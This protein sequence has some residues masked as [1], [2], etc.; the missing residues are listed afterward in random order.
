[1]NV[2]H[3]IVEATMPL[4]FFKKNLA[5]LDVEGVEIYTSQNGS[6]IQFSMVCW[7]ELK[8]AGLFDEATISQANESGSEVIEMHF[9]GVEGIETYQ[10]IAVS[11]QHLSRH[12]DLALSAAAQGVGKT[13]NMIMERDTGYFIKLYLDEDGEN[14]NHRPQLS[15]GAN[16]V[17]A[18]AHAQGFQMIEFDCDAEPLKH[19]SQ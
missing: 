7:D 6:M 14:L 11:T 2:V 4:I 8:Q 3:T 18:W 13:D 12:D 16:M 19:F 5:K 1:M 17:I 15:L 9:K 10:T